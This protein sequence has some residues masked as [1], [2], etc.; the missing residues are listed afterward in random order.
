M[1]FCPYLMLRRLKRLLLVKMCS[2]A[3]LLNINSASRQLFQTLLY[4][5]RPCSR[6]RI[7]ASSYVQ[8]VRYADF[9]GAKISENKISIRAKR[10]ITFYL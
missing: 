7:F 10:S 1:I 8:D 3:H 9:A 4:L 2:N 6:A 5:L